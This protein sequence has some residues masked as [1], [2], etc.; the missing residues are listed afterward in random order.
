MIGSNWPRVRNLCN[1][2]L[3]LK[4]EVVDDDFYCLIG[5]SQALL[6]DEY[7]LVFAGSVEMSIN[8]I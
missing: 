5:A 6:S 2:M 3:L 8:K 4:S 1:G 7:Y